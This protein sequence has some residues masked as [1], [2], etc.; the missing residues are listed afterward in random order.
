MRFQITARDAHGFDASL[1][2]K[3]QRIPGVLTAVPVLQ[4]GHRVADARGDNVPRDEIAKLLTQ[5]GAEG[6]APARPA[7]SI[8]TFVQVSIA[9]SA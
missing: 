8:R 3:V 1:L 5:M 9:S 7:T 2:S 4:E 6:P